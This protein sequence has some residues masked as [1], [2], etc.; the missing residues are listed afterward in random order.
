VKEENNDLV[1]ESLKKRHDSHHSL[2][3]QTINHTINQVINMGNPEENTIFVPEVDIS[4]IILNR[5]LYILKRKFE[6]Y[7]KEIM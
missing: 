5:S 6:T 2:G 3:Q 4:Q 7:N 1:E